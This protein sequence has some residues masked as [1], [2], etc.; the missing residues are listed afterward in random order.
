MIKILSLLMGVFFS[1]FALPQED[2]E[3]ANA[4]Y[5]RGINAT[6]YQEREEAFNQ[7]LFLYHSIE[8]E[9]RGLTVEVDRGIANSYFQLGE[10]AR[11]VLYYQ[12][13]L[14]VNPNDESAS[15]NIALVRKKLGLPQVHS[16]AK[17]WSFRSQPFVLWGIIIVFAIFSWT[18]GF[19]S[20]FKK[21]L[22]VLT[23][24]VLFL[25]IGNDLFLY[26]TTPLK[27]VVVKTSAFYRTPGWSQ[28]YVKSKPLLAGSEVY[29]LQLAANKQ[30]VKIR[31]PEGIIGYI[32]VENIR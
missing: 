24:V 23:L 11:A 29:I 10:Y 22:G 32:P 25:F 17:I 9:A 26:Y 6:N 1:L 8:E 20:K 18:I 4:A 19:S 13:A 27:G 28:P 21:G 7:A 5:Q 30:W 31:D 2:F 14:L 12:R 15:D 3:K 16:E